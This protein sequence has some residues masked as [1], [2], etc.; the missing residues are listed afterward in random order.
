VGRKAGGSGTG[1]HQE[2]FGAPAVTPATT[3]TT[4]L[5]DLL[6]ETAQPDLVSFFSPTPSAGPLCE[7]Q[8]IGSS[9]WRGR[10]PAGRGPGSALIRPTTPSCCT[11]PRPKA[12]GACPATGSGGAVAAWCADPVKRRMPR[13]GWGWV[14]ERRELEVRSFG[15]LYCS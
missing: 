3:Y 9:S 14:M 6:D 5:L 13:V 7:M 1:F 12:E 11:R 10:Q 4:C 15:L 2:R 8:G